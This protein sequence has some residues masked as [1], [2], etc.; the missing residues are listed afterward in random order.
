M[1]FKLVNGDLSFFFWFQKPLYDMFSIS[2]NPELE[3]AAQGSRKGGRIPHQPRN[4]QTVSIPTMLVTV[5][6]ECEWA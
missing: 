6:S 1:V 5:C 3:D 4:W 2:K